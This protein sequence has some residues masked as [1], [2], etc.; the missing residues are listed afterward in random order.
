M[1]PPLHVGLP[2]FQHASRTRTLQK[3]RTDACWRF[4]C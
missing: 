3:P 1:A 4:S 2:G